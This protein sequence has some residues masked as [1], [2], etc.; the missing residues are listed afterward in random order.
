[1]VATPVEVV[2]HTQLLKSLQKITLKNV[3]ARR[4]GWASDINIVPSPDVFGLCN[5]IGVLPC[6]SGQNL[7]PIAPH[8]NRF[9]QIGQLCH[10]T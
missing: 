1:M 7:S 6:M 10:S 9:G 4:V 5:L 8:S 3:I 2:E